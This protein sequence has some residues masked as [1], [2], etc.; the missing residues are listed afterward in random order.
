M[1]CPG[2]GALAESAAKFCMQCGAALNQAAPAAAASSL[3]ENPAGVR[4]RPLFGD[5]PSAPQA[6]DAPSATAPRTADTVASTTSL[7]P[8]T[9][10]Q[11]DAYAPAAQSASQQQWRPTAPPPLEPKTWQMPP[12]TGTVGRA[13][14]ATEVVGV[15]QRAIAVIIDLVLQGVA[16][17]VVLGL[18]SV[19]A[20]LGAMGASSSRSGT[21]AAGLGLY[22]L[23]ALG[24]VLVPFVYLGVILVYPI[25]MEKKYGATVG[26]MMAGIRVVT[27]TG[28]GISWGQSIGRNLLRAVDI[29]GGYLVAAVCV[30]NSP[31]R[32]RVGDMA[33]GTLVVRR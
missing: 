5:Q 14:G 2:C 3:Q 29:I 31:M 18:L 17:L 16:L 7:P 26:K 20:A 23:S 19:V 32:Q 15:G 28:G 8:P 33:A 22:G 24:I 30:W 4:W 27:L 13:I 21:A 25:V 11:A 6:A 10:A 1:V 9:V 12:S